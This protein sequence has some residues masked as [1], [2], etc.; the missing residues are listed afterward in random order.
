MLPDV[1][2]QTL[3]AVV[4]DDEPQLQ[5]TKTASQL[6]LPVAIINHRSRFRRLI[7]QIFRQ[8]AQRL[9]QRLTV[10]DAKAV[11]IES[12]EHP[13]MRIKGVTVSQL[14]A[15]MNLPKLR[16]QRRRP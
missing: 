15:A 3:H 8:N 6:N 9:N 11:A 13:L 12:R 4:S 10:G 5:R 1:I 14:Q 7:A 16:A 2:L